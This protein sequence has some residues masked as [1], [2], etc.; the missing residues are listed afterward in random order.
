MFKENPEKEKS[1]PWQTSGT[2][3]CRKGNV[4]ARAAV[5]KLHSSPA[6]TGAVSLTKH[7]I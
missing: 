5:L 6:T 3:S 1:S 7:D 4:L 2:A